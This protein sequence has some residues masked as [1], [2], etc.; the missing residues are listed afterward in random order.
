MN[1]FFWIK[2]S[3][4]MK[5]HDV[6]V[7]KHSFSIYGYFF[8]FSLWGSRSFFC[9]TFFRAKLFKPNS[10]WRNRKRNVTC[11]AVNIYTSI[12]ASSLANNGLKSSRFSFSIS[13]VPQTFPRTTNC[14][15]LSIGKN[16]KSFFAMF[17]FKGNHYAT[18]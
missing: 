10:T 4:S 1:V 14:A 6:T 18:S 9:K 5:L 11:Y 7:L 3:S 15:I 17:T 12:I 2:N 13:N 8:I 16:L